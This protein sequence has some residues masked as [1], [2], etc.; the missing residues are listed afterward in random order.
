M[1]SAT[2]HTL[3]TIKEL[4][5]DLLKLNPLQKT[6]TLIKP[7]LFCFSYFLCAYYA[8]WGLAIASVVCLLFA[9]FVSTSH[10]LVHKNLG[11]TK[12]VNTFFLCVIEAITL[13]SGHSFRICH[14]NH[15][16]HF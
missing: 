3:P 16:K 10:D 4:G 2:S 6:W 8:Y 1:H 12:N 14:L 15:H 5:M 9:T 7:F 11:L 13:R